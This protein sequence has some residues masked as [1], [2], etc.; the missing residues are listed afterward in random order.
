MTRQRPADGEHLLLPTGEQAGTALA[1]RF[2]LGEVLVGELLVQLLAA[3]AKTEVLGHRE[4]EEDSPPLG[5]VG[6]REASAGARRQ[7]CEV[8]AV[9]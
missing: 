5:H 2:Q 4:A 3:V 6:D 7:R 8:F 9:Q 1:Q